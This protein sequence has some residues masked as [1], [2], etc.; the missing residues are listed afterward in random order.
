MGRNLLLNCADHGLRVAGLDTNPDK[1]KALGDEDAGKTLQ[2]NQVSLVSGAHRLEDGR[3]GCLGL[4]VI[5]HVV[6]AAFSSPGASTSI[7]VFLPSFE[8]FWACTVPM[9]LPDLCL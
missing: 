9:T 2:L 4:G 5:Q 8:S 1:V 7:V 6:A 3:N